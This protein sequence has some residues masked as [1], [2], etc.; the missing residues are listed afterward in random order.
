MRGVQQHLSILF[1]LGVLGLQV[2]SSSGLAVFLDDHILVNAHALPFPLHSV[3]LSTIALDM[4][5]GWP[6]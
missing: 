5:G 2:F 3:E 1:S 6:L 4:H